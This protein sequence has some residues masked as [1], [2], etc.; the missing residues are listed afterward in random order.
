[1]QIDLNHEQAQMVI[2]CVQFAVQKQ[3]EDGQ[4]LIAMIEAAF[5]PPRAKRARPKAPSQSE[6]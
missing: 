5:A 6:G 2:N 1:M 3:V 4:A